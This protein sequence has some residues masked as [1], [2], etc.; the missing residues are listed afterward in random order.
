MLKKRIIPVQLLLND[1][2]VKTLNFDQY[3][4]VGDP[5]QSAKVYSAQYADELIFL[6]INRD[7]RTID[8][9]LALLD[10]LAEVCFMPLSVGGGIKTIEDVTSLIKHGADKIVLN[11]ILYNSLDVVKSIADKFGSQSIVASID[12]KRDD[13]NFFFEL[14]SNC[15][16]KKENIDLLELLYLL[17]KSGAGELFINSINNDGMM[18]GYD[19]DLIKYVMNHTN[20]PLIACGGAGN[21]GHLKDA[22]TQSNVNALACGSMFNFGDNNP[23]RAKAFLS[24][25]GFLFKKV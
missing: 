16:R 23:I 8:P 2:L 17:E 6:N 21:Y 5:I 11:S 19:L 18:M 12:I 15:G 24:N 20:L 1:R 7:N 3:R 22:F 9:L 13:K 25:Y 14:Y 10:K 4:D